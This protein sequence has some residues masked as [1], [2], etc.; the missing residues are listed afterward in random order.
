MVSVVTVQK[1]VIVCLTVKLGTKWDSLSKLSW[2]PAT[3]AISAVVFD[4]V[5]EGTQSKTLF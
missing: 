4:S 3:S 5:V 1:M 2:Y